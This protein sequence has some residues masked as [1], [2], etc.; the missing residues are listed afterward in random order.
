MA[1]KSQPKAKA[2]PKAKAAAKPKAKARIGQ[3][4]PKAK[5][6]SKAKPRAKAKQVVGRTEPAVNKSEREEC[7][8]GGGL[9][10]WMGGAQDI[11]GASV[12][13]GNPPRHQVEQEEGRVPV[14]DELMPAPLAQ[15]S[16]N[17]QSSADDGL[18]LALGMT[19]GTYLEI[20]LQKEEPGKHVAI[21][22][23]TSSLGRDSSGWLVE[24]QVVGHSTPT[25][26]SAV[27]LLYS[28]GGLGVVHL[29]TSDA[30]LCPPCVLAAGK[31][32]L[33]VDTWRIRPAESLFES[34][35]PSHVTVAGRGSTGCPAPQ[36]DNQ[37]RK[38]KAAELR[39]KLIHK[40]GFVE[41]LAQR[42]QERVNEQEPRKKKKRS[43]RRRRSSGSDSSSSRSSARLRTKTPREIAECEP[44]RQMS[45][46][47]LELNK[48]LS[49]H[50]AQLATSDLARVRTYLQTLYLPRQAPGAVGMRNTKELSVIAEVLDDLTQGNLHMAGDKLVQRFKAIQKAVADQGWSVAQH[51]EVAG[52]AEDTVLTGAEQR[53]AMREEKLRNQ[54]KRAVDSSGSQSRRA[55]ESS[56]SQ[57]KRAVDSG[58]QFKRAVDSGGKGKG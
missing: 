48:Q 39:E 46:F 43:R 56:G 14:R 33:H 55:V 28:T 3:A 5:A 13:L 53:T 36:L 49:G 9:S 41:Q 27:A 57:F 32:L 42:A 21:V 37:A 19:A 34:W 51:L 25:A 52:I 38:M 8:D 23:V 44:G 1:P 18:R 35:L 58:S 47:L 22:Q 29:C 11:G 50:S 12:L 17:W 26:G 40:R 31:P 20:D 30:R 6:K 10:H 2:K 4:K 24:V 7:D 15:P 16:G 45:G 54:L